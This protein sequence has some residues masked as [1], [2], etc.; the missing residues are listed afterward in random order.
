MNNN[1]N[2]YNNNN[3]NNNNN[4][5]N[6]NNNNN[7]DEYNGNNINNIISND[8]NNNLNNNTNINNI[9]DKN[10][11]FNYIKKNKKDYVNILKLLFNDVID[12]K[13]MNF[14][15]SLNTNIEK[16]VEIFTTKYIKILNN[17]RKEQKIILLEKL[18]NY[19]LN[20]NEIEKQLKII[21]KEINQIKTFKKLKNIKI[22]FK[23]NLIIE[24][25]IFFIED[26]LLK[27]KNGEII[28]RYLFL[29]Q[30]PNK[31][32][33]QSNFY[34]EIQKNIRES[35][36]GFKINTPWFKYLTLFFGIIFNFCDKKHELNKLFNV[37]DQKNLIKILY[38]YP[39]IKKK[40]DKKSKKKKND[41]SS[42]KNK[43]KDQDLI[44]KGMSQIGSIISG[45]KKKKHKDK[46]G[47][48][49]NKS[50]KKK[51][52]INTSDK[53]S[54]AQKLFISNMKK[55]K[56]NKNINNTNNVYDIYESNFKYLMNNYFREN[57]IQIENKI[58]LKNPFCSNYEIIPDYLF[59]KYKLQNNSKY[60]LDKI[61]DSYDY[62]KYFNLLQ[63]LRTNDCD[64]EI[65]K[66]EK[67]ILNIYFDFLNLYK[68]LLTI[69][70]IIYQRINEHFN[71]QK[72]TINN[73]QKNIK[74]NL[75]LQKNDINYNNQNTYMNFI[76]NLN[77]KTT[78]TKKEQIILKK[79]NF[80]LKQKKELNPSNYDYDKKLKLIHYYINKLLLNI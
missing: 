35:N 69:K 73:H 56:L 6:N 26:D 14:N 3:N 65:Y 58:K 40:N 20:Q 48:Q 7:N 68:E 12:I 51:Y 37:N 74:S 5:N 71:N 78:K 45:G 72:E 54:I 66:F 4:D 44:K 8:N 50:K 17:A 77:K 29:Q 62:E 24:K 59:S 23:F 52:N 57:L 19:K 38:S 27:Y 21:N 32:L 76:K 60:N 15:K 22:D 30:Y 36:N 31:N 43:K 79:I 80:L 64:K 70:Y 18:K 42:K 16:I 41:S 55:I 53:N 1:N 61:L 28:S 39:K 11:F 47:D 75:K 25:N 13:K 67:I 10:K 33:T 63:I 9:I 46:Q 2:N 49:K 34:N